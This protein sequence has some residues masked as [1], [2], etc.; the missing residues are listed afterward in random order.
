MIELQQELVTLRHDDQ[1]LGFYWPHGFD[2]VM[3]GSIHWN[4]NIKQH[5]FQGWKEPELYSVT[6]AHDIFNMLLSAGAY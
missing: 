6:E 1:C 2:Q 3:I 4:P 5:V